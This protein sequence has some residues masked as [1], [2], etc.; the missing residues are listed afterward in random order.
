MG[1]DARSIVEL[2]EIAFWCD[3][4]AIAIGYGR[5]PVSKENEI[6]LISP[7]NVWADCEFDKN[8]VDKLS[9]AK[10]L[11]ASV[12]I[13]YLKKQFSPY[14]W[15]NIID[16][17]IPFLGLIE[18]TNLVSKDRYG[19]NHILYITNY[20]PHTDEIFKKNKEELLDIYIE[21]LKKINPEFN[22]NWILDYKY[23]SVSAAQPVIPKNYS[24]N[25]PE[26]ESPVENLFIGNTTQIYPEDRGTNYS[27]AMGRKMAALAL[28]KLKIK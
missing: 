21:N 22:K 16:D 10:Y 3:G 20:L 9:T 15:M 12:F 11:G 14:Y 23:N 4:S 2:G 5:T 18:H 25:I 8:Y 17:E 1:K 26:I 24:S 7:C 6:R 19:D 27:V 28:Q 13:L